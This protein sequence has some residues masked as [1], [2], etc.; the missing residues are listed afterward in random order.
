MDEL[1]QREF[2][3]STGFGSQNPGDIFHI[4]WMQEYFSI[5]SV[6]QPVRPGKLTWKQK[7]EV[8]QLIFLFNWVMFRFHV[9]FEGCLRYEDDETMGPCPFPQCFL[10]R[11]FAKALQQAHII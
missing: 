1:L 4:N 11:F 6:E 10:R 5:M 8:R 9:D 3:W 2:A 7:N